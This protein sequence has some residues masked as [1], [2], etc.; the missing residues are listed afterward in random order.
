[1]NLEFNKS[2]LITYDKFILLGSD[3]APVN[4]KADIFK[5]I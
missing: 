2:D 3:N 1:M 4:D 5:N